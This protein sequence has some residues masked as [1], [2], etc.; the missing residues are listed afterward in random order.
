MDLSKCIA[1]VKVFIVRLIWRYNM[2][3]IIRIEN[4]EMG[5]VPEKKVLD[6][7]NM[8][9]YPGEIIGYIGPNGAGKSTTIKILLGLLDFSHGDIE[10][11]GETLNRESYAYKSKIGYVP[12]AAALYDSLTGREYLDFVGGMFGMSQELIDH[13]SIGLTEVFGIHANLDERIGSYSKGMKQKLLIVSSMIHNP[14]LLIFDEPLNGMDANSVMIFKEVLDH[15]AKA[16]KTILYSSHIMDVVEKISDRIL[17][18]N[19]GKI[20]ADGSFEA[21]STQSNNASLE[22]LFNDITG[23][24]EYIDLASQF[25]SVM[26]GGVDE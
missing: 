7:I 20:V 19:E 25:V 1:K 8:S 16:G 15:L 21:L 26:T 4:L 9:I 5:Y 11:F 24:D 17:L 22:S 13:R 6:G 12:E 18:I 10:I 2:N 3:P 14:E 23:F